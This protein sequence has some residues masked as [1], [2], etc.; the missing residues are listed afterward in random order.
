MTNAT[1]PADAPAVPD[2][3]AF[4]RWELSDKAITVFIS[5]EL[6][7]RLERE[8]LE[9][10][11]A[12][13]RRG[14]E[15]GGL[16]LGRTAEAGR[17]LI[18]VDSFEPVECDHSRGPLYMFGDED[19]KRL[20]KAVARSGAAVVGFFRSNTRR[21]IVLDEDDLALVKEY[22]ASPSQICMLVKPFAMKP[23]TGAIFYW[24]NGALEGG[25]A[26]QAFPF[27]RAEIEKSLANMI[28]KPGDPALS[29]LVPKQAAAQPPARP[30]A[31]PASPV[32]PPGREERPP[33]AA[34]SREAAPARPPVAARKE[35]KSAQPARPVVVPKYEQ[36]PLGPVLVKKEEAVQAAEGKPPAVQPAPKKEEKP[37]AAARPAAPAVEVAKSEPAPAPA[38]KAGPAAAPAPA[39]KPA[40]PAPASSDIPAAMPIPDAAARS[41]LLANRWV[42]IGVIV[43]LLAGGATYRFV[44]MNRAP[45]Q[46]AQQTDPL[47]LS[48]EPNAGQ[49]VLRWNRNAPAVQTASR[50]LLTINDGDNHED[51]E[52]DLVQLR[53]GNIVYSPITN[54]VSFRLEVTDVKGGKSVSES[55]RY[56]TGR[57]SP[58]VPM[59]QAPQMPQRLTP[60][61]APAAQETQTAAAAPPARPSSE[62]SG[63]PAQTPAQAQP[64]DNTPLVSA[65]PAVTAQ[66]PK[67]LSLAARL[68]AATPEQLLE[69]PQVSTQ[70]SAMPTASALPGAV[71]P[72]A[73]LPSAPPPPAQQATAQTPA[74]NRPV[75]GGVVVPAQLLRRAPVNYPPLAR[76]ARVSGTVR[77]EAV[78]GVDGRVKSVRAL[79]GPPLL[80]S[81]ATDS[82]RQW[83]YSPATLNGK[84]T[85][86][87]TLID[88]LFNPPR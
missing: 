79:S 55:M 21:D 37:T 54:D 64:A 23:S 52:I 17:R 3:T 73:A 72:G 34:S 8:T 41:S 62:A 31:K 50:A 83:V 46:Q 84:P 28:V 56:L 13:T 63:T 24:E 16:L 35:E 43:L 10:F 78:I 39:A 87:T 74:S 6:I 22:F 12:V 32:L 30:A 36:R 25:D 76:Q 70:S 49:L 58:S 81:A 48:V 4:Y 33:A 53:N 59:Q 7:E 2:P 1:V 82:V 20:E 67:P 29:A 14:S 42:W 38:E 45:Q 5:L 88:L 80:L 86:T 51:V 57:P 11:K 26:A 69:L 77:V 15:I 44:F 65:T 75:T 71:V 68:S 9:A 19:K 18:L 27:R 61:P 47:S 85:E 60:A 40:E 66:P